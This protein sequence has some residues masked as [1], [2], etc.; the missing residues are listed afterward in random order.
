MM[1]KKKTKLQIAREQA[2]T[3]IKRTNG[4]IDELGVHTGS[5]YE[6]LTGIQ[7]FFDQIRNVP[8]D[9]M[10]EYEKLKNIRLN[11]KQQVEKIEA[12]YKN[13]FLTLAGPVGWAIAGVALLSSGFFLWKAKS[14]KDRLESVYMRI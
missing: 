7:N 6:N 1:E 10:L 8:E 9:K 14:D 12:D 13:A 2:D 5:L 11:W 3:A 4:K